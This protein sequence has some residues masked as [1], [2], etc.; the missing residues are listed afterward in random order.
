MS[1]RHLTLLSAL[2]FASLYNASIWKIYFENNSITSIDSFFRVISFF[3]FLSGIMLFI[4]SFFNYKYIQ[5][6]VLISFYLLASPSL[7]FSLSLGVIFD[8]S[9]LQNTLETDFRESLDLITF[10][11]IVTYLFLGVLPALVISTARIKYDRPIKQIFSNLIMILFS[12]LL[13][14]ASVY[15]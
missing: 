8:E 15:A 1:G 3:G 5:K 7:Y 2:L 6:I 11:L 14:G 10:P 4:F 9:M 12:L 13:A